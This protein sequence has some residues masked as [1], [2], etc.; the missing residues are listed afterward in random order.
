MPRLM[1]EELR[2]LREGAGLSRSR[3]SRL[4]VG[5]GDAGVG[6][7][8]IQAL[9]TYPGRIPEADIIETL[10]RALGVEPGHFYEYPVALAR[11][12]ARATA[13][14]AAARSVEEAAV[15]H[16]GRPAPSAARPGDAGWR[17]AS[18]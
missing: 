8:T 10:A 5:P 3:L 18:S 6:E 17:G 1:Y 12:D 14:E 2:A 7:K 15:P 11:R 13:V 4:T 9:E 16:D